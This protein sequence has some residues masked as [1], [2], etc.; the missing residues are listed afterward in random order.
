MKAQKKRSPLFDAYEAAHYLDLHPGTLS[1]WRLQGIGP[2]YVRI[3]KNIRYRVADLDEWI[4]VRRVE[5]D[6]VLSHN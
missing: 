5:S 1:N 6:P 3:G 4:T 2:A